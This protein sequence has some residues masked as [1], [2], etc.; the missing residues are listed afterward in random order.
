MITYFLDTE[1]P[2]QNEVFRPL[3][4][5]LF[6]QRPVTGWPQICLTHSWLEGN[7]FKM[8]SCRGVPCWY[9]FHIFMCFPLAHTLFCT[10]MTL[11][12]SRPFKILY[13]YFLLQRNFKWC[14]RQLWQHSDTCHTHLNP[15]GSWEWGLYLLYYNSTLGYETRCF[16]WSF[17]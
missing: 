9:R 15:R 5:D 10:D 7:R 11:I 1:S 8:C 13:V 4:D 3:G 14:W 16:V 2:Q 17:H 12:W 6:P